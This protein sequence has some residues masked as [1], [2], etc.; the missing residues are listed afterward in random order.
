MQADQPGQPRFFLLQK[1]ET[2]GAG[3]CRSFSALDDNVVVKVVLGAV[4][5]QSLLDRSE[6]DLDFFLNYILVL[7]TRF[8]EKKHYGLEV[9]GTDTFHK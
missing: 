5:E 4:L 3:F 9:L 8:Q 1:N 7:K 6:S 2:S